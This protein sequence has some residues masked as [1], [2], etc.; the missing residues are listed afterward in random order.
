MA[1]FVKASLGIVRVV[2]A[3]TKRER[4][5]FS[6][7]EQVIDVQFN[8]TS[9]KVTYANNADAGGVTSR[10]QSRQNASVQPAVLS[11]DLEYDTAET[12]DVDV[13]TLTA[14]VRR[15]VRPP[16]DKPKDPAPL[17]QFLWGSFL[18][19]GRVTQVTED[20]DYFS[21]DGRPL[22]AKLTLSITEQDPALEANAVGPGA[23]TD[24]R[25]AEPGGAPRPVPAPRP[26]DAPPGSGP[27]QSGTAGPRLA[28]AALDGES[29]AGLAVRV[30]GNPAAWRALAGGVDDPLSLTAGL[31]VRAGAEIEL[32]AGVGV[33]PGFAAGATVGARSGDDAAEVAGAAVSAS[34]GLLPAGIQLTAAGG[35]TAASGRLAA[36]SARTEVAAARGSFAVP[37]ATAPEAAGPPDPRLLGYGRGLPLRARPHAATAAEGRAGGATSLTARARPRE[38]PVSARGGT[39]WERL[40]PGARGRAEADA[41]QRARDARPTTM[42]WKPGGE[43]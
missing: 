4:A 8:P 32:S 2:T 42:R 29:L 27:G 36:T 31:T 33:S 39:P 22:R 30:G 5:T 37:A 26:L 28:V 15:F 12:P 3:A 10:A 1:E 25:A 6:P 19:N 20:I 23:R 7:P 43:C 41:A 17:V 13:R 21:P 40:T 18:F 24:D 16:R 35:V 11:F 34:A 14:A 9:M 38:A